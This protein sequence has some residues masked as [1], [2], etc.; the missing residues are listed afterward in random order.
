MS[1]LGFQFS[2]GFFLSLGATL[3]PFFYAYG[4]Y[5]T[6][7]NNQIQ[8]LQSKMFESSFGMWPRRCSLSQCGHCS[9]Y[10][11]CA[12]F[13]MLF[14][15]ILSLIYLVCAIRTNIIFVIIF[16]GLFFDFAFLTG[17][18][19]QNALG[20][21]DTAN[22]LQ[23]VSPPMLFLQSAQEHPADLRIDGRCLGVYSLHR[24]V[25]DLHL[26]D[27]CRARLS[28]SDPCRRPQYSG[29]GR[30]P[31]GGGKGGLRGLNEA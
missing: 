16:M 9:D 27:A 30:K 19:W 24:G 20:E 4:S 29:Q 2:G 21:H 18:Y 23:V 25:V 11:S 14:M 13:F 7:P 26:T 6:D 15:A 28:L 3:T 8:G 12:G 10:S 1:D 31:K 22:K 5:V 17:A